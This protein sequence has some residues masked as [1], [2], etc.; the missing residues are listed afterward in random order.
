MKVMA[1]L[2]V[3]ASA[4]GNR[5]GRSHKTVIKHLGSEVYNDPSINKLI[6]LIKEKELADLYLLGG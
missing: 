2:G 3:S 6:E 4:I 5:I 1:D